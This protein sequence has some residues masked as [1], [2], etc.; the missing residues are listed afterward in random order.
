MSWLISSGRSTQHWVANVS[1][2]SRHA[3]FRGGSSSPQPFWIIIQVVLFTN[4]LGGLG[5]L[6]LYYLSLVQ[7]SSKCNVLRL[8]L[9]SCHL[10]WSWTELFVFR[11]KWER[12]G[13][14]RFFRKEE[15]LSLWGKKGNSGR[16]YIKII[17]TCASDG[18]GVAVCCCWLCFIW[19]TAVRY[20][21]LCCY[22]LTTKTRPGTYHMLHHCSPVGNK[23]PTKW[24]SWYRG[25]KMQHSQIHL[26]AFAFGSKGFRLVAGWEAV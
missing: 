17:Y 7:T 20:T 18:G 24:Y 16:L 5:G 2:S 13:R 10:R 21:P 9:M 11:T 22:W 1:S 14:G 8:L 25:I 15:T 26:E 19:L 6:G 4:S 12:G 3:E 23:S